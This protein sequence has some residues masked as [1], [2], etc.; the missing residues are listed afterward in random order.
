VFQTPRFGGSSGIQRVSTAREASERLPESLTSVAHQ[1][2]FIRWYLD[3][4]GLKRIST[5]NLFR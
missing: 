5:Q 3:G 4:E 1:G 2:S